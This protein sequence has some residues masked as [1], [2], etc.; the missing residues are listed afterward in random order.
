MQVFRP[1]STATSEGLYPWRLYVYTGAL[2]IPSLTAGLAFIN[3]KLGYES[4]GAFCMLPIRPFWYR[5]ALAWIP[6]YLIAL[7][8]TG[9]A[10]AI[11][12]YIR[13]EF[14]RISRSIMASQSTQLP[15]ALRNEGYSGTT[16]IV[17]NG[18]QQCPAGDNGDYASLQDN[19]GKRHVLSGPSMCA[20]PGSGNSAFALDKSTKSTPGDKVEQPFKCTGPAEFKPSKAPISCSAEHSD[21]T[22][23]DVRIASTSRVL[24]ETSDTVLQDTDFSSDPERYSRSETTYSSTSRQHLHIR[25]QLR[26]VFIYPLVYTL[27]WV[28]PLLNHCTTYSDKYAQHPL[29]ALRL[30]AAVCI[31]SMGFVDC[32]VFFLRERPWLSFAAT[33][34]TF[35]ERFTTWS[36][37]APEGTQSSCSDTWWKERCMLT[38][39]P[40]PSTR[41]FVFLEKLKRSWNTRAMQRSDDFARIAATQ[42]RVRLQHERADRLTTRSERSAIPVVT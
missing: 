26:L 19:S 11:Y 9:L 36:L 39:Q 16:I 31:S 42:A 5:L 30:G 33:E 32:L 23:A 14:H 29:W 21:S 24:A 34:G 12:V 20:G 2:L 35:C 18:E 3:P 22:A 28:L 13:L 1:V 27:M 41:K 15:Q 8:I 38:S 7:V 4:L 40:P 10:V 6:R 25:H 17:P 37:R